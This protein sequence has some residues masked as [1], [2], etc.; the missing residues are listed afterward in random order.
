V[1]AGNVVG[2]ISGGC[3]EGAVYE[4]CQQVLVDGGTPA[5]ARFDYSDDDAFAGGLTCGGEIDV[6]VQCVDRADRSHLT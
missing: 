1:A 2:S 5:R 6:L 3:V 4:L